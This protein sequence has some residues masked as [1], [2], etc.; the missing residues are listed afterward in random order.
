MTI[1]GDDKQGLSNNIAK[2]IFLLA[3]TILSLHLADSKYIFV[4]DHFPD[5]KLKQKRILENT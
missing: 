5:L 2:V 3:G 4:F 1:K